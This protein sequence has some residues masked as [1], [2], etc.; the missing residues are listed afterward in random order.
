M[1]ASFVAFGRVLAGHIYTCSRLLYIYCANGTHSSW[2]RTSSIYLGG[3]FCFLRQK[4]QKNTEIVLFG[5]SI[6]STS[7]LTK[8]KQQ[9][10][11]YPPKTC[12][13]THF[14]ASLLFHLF[15][16]SLSRPTR[17]SK[18]YIFFGGPPRAPRRPQRAAAAQ[19]SRD[20]LARCRPHLHN[21]YVVV[22]TS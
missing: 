16:P 3:P 11:L 8:G 6:H 18:V 9:F 2:K 10:P 20:D 15:A 13:I 19:A 4:T 5:W 1:C 14:T 17:P 12:R 21:I 22:Y 7:S